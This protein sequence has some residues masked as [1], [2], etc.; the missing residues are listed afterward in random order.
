[1]PLI[2]I[3]NTPTSV[4]RK[5][6]LSSKKKKST[7]KKRFA[8]GKTPKRVVRFDTAK[9]CEEDPKVPFEI[10]VVRNDPL[11][12]FTKQKKF[13]NFDDDD[14]EEE[15]NILDIEEQRE[16]MTDLMETHDTVQEKKVQY[17][18]WIADGRGRFKLD[19]RTTA[20]EGY[21]PLNNVG[22]SP[23]FF[24]VSKVIAT[25]LSKTHCCT[26]SSRQSRVV[27]IQHISRV[28]EETFGSPNRGTARDADFDTT[29]VVQITSS[30]KIRRTESYERLIRQKEADD[31]EE[32]GNEALDTETDFSDSHVIDQWKASICDLRSVIEEQERTI[33][34]TP[35]PIRFDATKV[36]NMKT[37]NRVDRPISPVRFAMD[38]P[39]SCAPEVEGISTAVRALSDA[40]DTVTRSRMRSGTRRMIPILRRWKYT[41]LDLAFRRWKRH[42]THHDKK[43]EKT[44][45]RPVESAT[46]CGQCGIDA[47]G[48]TTTEEG[49]DEYGVWYCGSCWESYYANEFFISPTSTTTA[50]STVS[51]R[52]DKIERLKRGAR[53][54]LMS[55]SAARHRGDANDASAKTEDIVGDLSVDLTRKTEDIVGDLSTSMHSTPLAGTDEDNDDDARTL[56]PEP[57]VTTTLATKDANRPA[58]STNVDKDQ[59]ETKTLRSSRMMSWFVDYFVKLISVG[60]LVSGMLYYHERQLYRHGFLPPHGKTQHSH[61]VDHDSIGT[62]ASPFPKQDAT[63]GA[64]KRVEVTSIGTV[65][66]LVDASSPRGSDALATTFDMPLT[67]VYPRNET[68]FKTFEAPNF[69]VV[70]SNPQGSYGNVKLCLSLFKMIMRPN[71]RFVP[72]RVWDT[73]FTI[74]LASM[75]IEKMTKFI[76]PMFMYGTYEFR[77]TMFDRLILARPRVTFTSLKQRTSMGVSIRVAR[78]GT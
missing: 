6:G 53:R 35:S 8:L 9:I 55:P 24:N 5:K 70:V 75:P 23:D 42:G 51:D 43:E 25:P 21:V 27:E 16:N 61:R 62:H 47:S 39:D 69:E 10:S 72:E 14:E 36:K 7:R 73:C 66:H 30:V 2:D 44:D 45:A 38:S 18:K 29:E 58:S 56:I 19:F 49:V 59:L 22:K 31:E 52:V 33:G 3:T 12:P 68:V 1:M 37:P 74:D 4:R 71:S 67:I 11:T 17:V 77:A 78:Q 57:P 26:S 46:Q 60:L 50:S 13:F 20:L 41:N 28:M 54:R 32:K 40:I 76:P 63:L 34:K 64:S 15:E 48:D 65:R